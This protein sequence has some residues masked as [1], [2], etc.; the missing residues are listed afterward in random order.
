VGW[1]LSSI[2]EVINVEECVYCKA[3]TDLS[4]GYVSIC[5]KCSEER[6]GKHKDSLT[7]EQ[8]RDALQAELL[9][10]TEKVAIASDEFKAITAEIPSGLPHP[11]GVQSIQNAM[12]EVIASHNELMRAHRRVSE[13]IEHGTVP[14]NLKGTG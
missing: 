9:A 6:E 11:D 13:F 5:V 8:I 10:A 7:E 4:E 14:R 1:Q 3:E 2:T 12:H